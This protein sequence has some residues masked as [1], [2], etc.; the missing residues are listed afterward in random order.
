MM[1]V[2]A[3]ALVTLVSG[4]GVAGALPFEIPTLQRIKG[5]IQPSPGNHLYLVTLALDDQPLF[6][7]VGQFTLVTSHGFKLAIGA[8]GGGDSVIPFDRIPVGQE[9]GQV[10]P[11][12]AILAL[13]RT[14]PA[15][16]MLEL[17]P[18]GTMALLFDLPLGATV[19]ALRLPDGSELPV[20][21]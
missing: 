8:G 16:V 17:G 9:V 10:L 11:S 4:Y 19:R 2:A 15:A 3:A 7:D 14:S 6:G 12:D 13:T 21:R 20:T 1:S 5:T 18:R